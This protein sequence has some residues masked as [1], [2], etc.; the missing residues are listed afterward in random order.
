MGM[1]IYRKGDQSPEFNDSVRGFTVIELMIVVGII[2]ILA[3]IAVPAYRTYT[4]RAMSSEA[5]LSLSNLYVAQTA[6][7]AEYNSYT[8][9][10]AELGIGATGEPRFRYGFSSS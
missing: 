7:R 1:C 5:K 6:Y 4:E 3:S 9:C 2:G 10:L 8:P